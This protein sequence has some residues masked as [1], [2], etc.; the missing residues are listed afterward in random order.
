LHVDL[1]ERLLDRKA[2]FINALAIKIR[3]TFRVVE[4][5][6]QVF[7]EALHYWPIAIFNRGG[8][9][10]LGVKIVEDVVAEGKA[11]P[12]FGLKIVGSQRVI[13]CFLLGGGII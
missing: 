4:T 8:A 7:W 1:I 9:T 5:G 11:T 3:K 12:S 6:I 13:G 10:R 2:R